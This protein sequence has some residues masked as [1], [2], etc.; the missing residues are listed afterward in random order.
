MVKLKKRKFNK[1]FLIL[2]ITLFVLSLLVYSSIPGSALHV[3]TSPISFITNPVYSS[4]TGISS[5]IKGFYDSLVESEKIRKENL[6]LKDENLQLQQRIK[7]LEEN[8]RRWEELKAALNIRDS[9]SDYTIIGAGVLT[10]EIGEWF[11]VF[12][13]NAGIR[14][15]INIDGLSSYA[16]VDANMNLVGRII[17]SDYSSS[18]VLPILNEGSTVS[19]KIN[20]PGGITLRVRGDLLLKELSKCRIDNIA[21][22]TAIKPGDEVITSGLGGLYPPGIP[23]GIVTEVTDGG[24]SSER[25]AVLR[26]YS[27]YKVLTDVFILKGLFDE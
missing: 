21:D 10:R 23:V 4:V 1:I 18:K 12:R 14:D 13:I 20:A 24:L 26:I 16:V 6:D 27:D 7:E 25:R 15:G 17:S 22:I 9:Y 11:D 2:I 5:S 19:G 8:G 3:I